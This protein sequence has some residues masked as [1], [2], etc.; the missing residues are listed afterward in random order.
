MKAISNSIKTIVK[1]KDV[2]ID[3]RLG[4]IVM[5]DTPE[6]IRMAERIV[7]LQDL[8]DSEVM[9]EVE[10]LE[11]KRSRLLELGV[12]WPNKLTLSPLTVGSA[13]VTL[14]DLR[15][16]SG[17]RLG[18]AVGSVVINADQQDQDGNILANPRIRVRNKDKAKIQIGDKVPVITTTSTSTG[19]ISDS[20]AYVDVGLKLEVEPSIYLDDEVAIKINLEV[21]NLVREIVSRNGTMAYQIGTRGASTTLR[22]KDGET[23]ILAGLISE[24][25][26]STGNRVPL[27]GDLP[28]AGRLFGSQ[29]DDNQRSEILLS[30]TPHIVRTIGRPDM[31]DAEFESGTESSIGTAGLR[32]SD[33]EPLP[34][35]AAAKEGAAPGAVVTPLTVPGPATAKAPLAAPALAVPA[36]A[37]AAATSG[38]VGVSWQGP[39]QVK[40]GEQFTAVVKLTSQQALR[41]MPVLLGFDPGVFQVVS[42]QEGDYFK[43]AKG[44]TAF[45]QR[46]DMAQGKIFVAAV[47]QSGNGSEVGINGSGALVS[48]NLKAIKATPAT[49]LQVLSAM[50]EPSAATPLALPVEHAV[51]VV[52]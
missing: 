8:G 23:Q 26:R 33:A 10:I 30:I 4:V 36:G 7:A 22:L 5:R 9:L 50:P 2:V 41:G 49:R 37:P 27:V 39:A 31:L 29:K 25:D 18:A 35:P 17:A 11:V 15:R 13:P 51:R 28:I 32:L 1:T 34:V 52:P 40:V 3:E 46:V 44:S 43:Q 19:F 48:V 42:V 20:V 6:A 21:S 47:R 12:Q 16:L 24:E 38:T 14:D 45:S